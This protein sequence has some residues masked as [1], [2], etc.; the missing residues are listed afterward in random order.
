DVAGRV[1]KTTLP[2][3]SLI[4]KTYHGNGVTASEKLT[5]S[6]GATIFT[7]SSTTLDANGRLLK[8]VSGADATKNWVTNTY[9]L[10]GNL[11]QTAS[12]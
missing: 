5:D 8:T 11:T 2:D 4:N 10:N 3:G 12:A 6:T 7:Q 1:I 9:D